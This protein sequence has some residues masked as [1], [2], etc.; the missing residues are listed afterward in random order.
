MHLMRKTVDSKVL[1]ARAITRAGR[2]MLARRFDSS[3]FVSRWLPNVM[4]L[5]RGLLIE[6]AMAKHMAG[7]PSPRPRPQQAT[8]R[9]MLTRAPPHHHYPLLPVITHGNAQARAVAEGVAREMNAGGP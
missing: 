1:A 3:F 4:L 6:P 2:H 7:L 5:R 9:R 8:D